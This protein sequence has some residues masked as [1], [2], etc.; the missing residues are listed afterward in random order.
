MAL[1]VLESLKT[2]MIT[3]VISA[4][5][6]LAGL[7][8]PINQVQES[9]NE[10]LRPD[11]LAKVKSLFKEKCARC[12]G[13]DGRGETVLAE[14]INP[15]DFTDEKW[16]K[17]DLNNEELAEI[18]ARGKGE[19]PAFGKKLT[20]QEIASLVLYVRQFIKTKTKTEQ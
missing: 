4:M 10:S 12:H 2:A 20:R 6:L 11:R 8:T 18:V 3:G 14:Q 1:P 5:L 13:E 19:M 17:S 15:P 16:S 7:V 9:R